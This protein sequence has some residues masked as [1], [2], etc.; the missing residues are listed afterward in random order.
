MSWVV[1]DEWLKSLA[2]AR[3]ERRSRP[4]EELDAVRFG[5]SHRQHELLVGI[6]FSV[7]VEQLKS[8]PLTEQ[9]SVKKVALEAEKAR[10]GVRQ[11]NDR[12]SL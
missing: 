12:A 2:A 6:H 7:R 1:G 3:K 4:S 8:H 11:P 9:A 10:D 5:P